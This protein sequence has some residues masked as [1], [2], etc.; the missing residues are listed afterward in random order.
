MCACVCVRVCVLNRNADTPLA[1]VHN[2]VD[3]RSLFVSPSLVV[4]QILVFVFAFSCVCVFV[5]MRRIPCVQLRKLEA[6][7]VKLAENQAKKLEAETKFAA[8][9]A[10]ISTSCVSVYLAPRA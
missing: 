1:L 4:F 5:R 6:N 10:E 8:L 3:T 9:D 7:P 2:A